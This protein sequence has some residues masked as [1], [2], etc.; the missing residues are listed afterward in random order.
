MGLGDKKNTGFKL[1]LSDFSLSKGER[2][3]LEPEQK[4]IIPSKR[5]QRNLPDLHIHW[6]GGYIRAEWG[7]R[8]RLYSHSLEIYSQQFRK[9]SAHMY[10]LH[11]ERKEPIRGLSSDEDLKIV[12][13]A[14]LKRDLESIHGKNL[15][16]YPTAYTLE[17]QRHKKEGLEFIARIFNLG[18]SLEK[19]F[20]SLE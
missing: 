20:T 13:S 16:L 12:K 1:V 2:A 18:P 7:A 3:V 11:L 6:S 8:E 9:K 4:R 14:L 15:G 10:T 19:V 17:L 5:I